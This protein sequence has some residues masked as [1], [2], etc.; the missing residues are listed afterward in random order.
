MEA[1]QRAT[2]CSLKAQTRNSPRSTMKRTIHPT[3][4]SVPHCNCTAVSE[5]LPTWVLHF[6]KR[7]LLHGRVLL[8]EVLREA[9]RE[10]AARLT[11]FF[12]SGLTASQSPR[13]TPTGFISV[14][15]MQPSRCSRP[16][17]GQCGAQGQ[18]TIGHSCQDVGSL[19]VQGLNPVA[20]GRRTAPRE[21]RFD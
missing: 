15:A 13:C 21:C 18:M 8:R 3:A 10:G 4:L 5:V 12:C 7:L 1:R 6:P 2:S 14:W 20:T 19:H 16:T 9:H 17:A 11:A